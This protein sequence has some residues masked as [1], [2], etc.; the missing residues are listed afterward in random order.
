MEGYP[1]LEEV[2]LAREKFEEADQQ[3]KKISKPLSEEEVIASLRDT[4]ALWEFLFPAAHYELLRLLIN[5]IIVSLER[6]QLFIQLEGLRELT[7]EMT[8]TGYFSDNHTTENPEA[9]FPPLEQPLHDDGTIELTMPFKAK[10]IGGHC[11]VIVPTPGGLPL[12]QT[13]ILRAVNNAFKWS[14][15]Q[16]Q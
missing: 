13:A 10:S 7:V 4:S 12:K 3:W 9:E 15:M 2:Q 6:L 5:R 14:E 11:N 8:E 16:C 1:N